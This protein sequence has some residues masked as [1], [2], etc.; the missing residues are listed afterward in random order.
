MNRTPDVERE[1]RLLM[2]DRVRQ[3]APPTEVFDRVRRRHRRSRQRAVLA[4]TLAVVAVV[5]AVSVV[6]R[7]PLDRTGH[8]VPATRGSLAGDTAL[9]DAARTLAIRQVFTGTAKMDDDLVTVPFAEQRDGYAVLLVVGQRRRDNA[10]A[11]TFVGR[12]PGTSALSLLDRSAGRSYP[13]TDIRYARQYVAPQSLIVTVYFRTPTGALGRPFG[14]VM[15]PPGDHVTISR[16]GTVGADCQRV[17]AQTERL[18]LR[19]GTALFSY[20]PDDRPYV[21]ILDR[22]TGQL[23]ALP[24][25]SDSRP[26]GPSAD[27]TAA[28][29]RSSFGTSLTDWQL[30]NAASALHGGYFVDPGVNEPPAGYVGLWAGAV[31]GRVVVKGAGPG[32]AYL[33]GARYRSG[34][35]ILLGL[36][37]ASHSN[38]VEHWVSGCV[39]AGTN[40]LVLAS[41]LRNWPGEPLVMVGPRAAVRAE[42]RFADSTVAGVPLTG[43]GGLLARRGEATEIRAYDRDGHLIGTGR[44][45]RGLA[46]VPIKGG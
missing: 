5:A 43:G 46:P 40:H 7:L 34:A 11:S 13:A 45:D 16:D 21:R 38:G 9:I 10:Y 36:T 8:Q 22:S 24:L 33:V 42:V 35:T 15:A 30:R 44:P 1:L 29:L 18:P 14:V 26:G 17:D 31:P 20:N 27:E 37:S 2:Q 4:S 41:R 39:P 32:V 3:L 12:A 23:A 19:D 25:R 6:L 28:A